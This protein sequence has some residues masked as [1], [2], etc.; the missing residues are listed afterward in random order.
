MPAS[1][2]R[3]AATAVPRSSARPGTASA[4]SAGAAARVVRSNDPAAE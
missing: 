4:P 3:S 2:A 1:F